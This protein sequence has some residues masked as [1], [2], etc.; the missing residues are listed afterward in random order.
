MQSAPPYPI[1][2]VV[3]PAHNEAAVIRRCLDALLVGFAPNE[4]DVVVACNGCTDDTAGI[5][6]SRWP[7]VRV[8]E[9]ARASKPS[10]LRAADE[11]LNTF[12][13]I[14]LDADVILPAASARLL[15]GSLQPGGSAV[16]ARPRCSYDVSRSDA[17]V[18]SYFRSLARVQSATNSIW[19]PVYGLSKAGRARFTVYPDIIADDLFADQWFEPSEI[20]IVDNTLATITAPLRLRDLIHISCRRRK[21]NAQIR[22]LPNGPESTASSTV[23]SLLSTVTSGPGAALDT[24]VYLALAIIVRVSTSVSPP[25]DWSR[26]ESSRSEI[27]ESNAYVEDPT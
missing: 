12:P 11:M 27:I 2:S 15:I 14:Y 22:A 16:A 4:L 23:R 17:L 21:G 9:I 19:G 5:V 7:A 13:R 3:I 24:L 8:I 6:R 25:A 20:V 10:A 26:D 1:G 18:R